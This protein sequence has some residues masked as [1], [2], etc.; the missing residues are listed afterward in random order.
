[1]LQLITRV[2]FSPSVNIFDTDRSG[3][4]GFEEFA[5]LWKYI[6]DW[7]VKCCIP[8]CMEVDLARVWCL[9]VPLIIEVLIFICHIVIENKPGKVSSDTL[10]RIDRVPL[11]GP[12]FGML[13][14][15]CDL[16]SDSSSHSLSDW[17][18]SSHL[19][20]TPTWLHSLASDYRH[21][22]FNSWSASTVSGFAIRSHSAIPVPFPSVRDASSLK[23]KICSLVIS[24]TRRSL[25]A[26][27][28]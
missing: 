10:T 6:K 4:I 3:T 14:I 5:G 2:C 24:F 12:S 20:I 16:T 18:N 27:P 11:L 13:L 8:T 25:E 23:D 22:C 15:R 21:I 26:W 19:Y 28:Y 7:W 1:M 17:L 9:M